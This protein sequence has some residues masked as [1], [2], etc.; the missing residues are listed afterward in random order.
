MYTYICFVTKYLK[1]LKVISTYHADIVNKSILT[2]RL[3]M[4]N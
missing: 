2:K 3:H 4:F 1:H